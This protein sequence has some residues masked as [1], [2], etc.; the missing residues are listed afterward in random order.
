[1][2]VLPHKYNNKEKEVVVAKERI[3]LGAVCLT[4]LVAMI[5]LAF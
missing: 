3:L 2:K 5:I 4:G 1:M